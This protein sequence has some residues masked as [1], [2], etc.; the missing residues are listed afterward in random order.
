MLSAEGPIKNI[1]GGG[2][3]G[4]GGVHDPLYIGK[5]SGSKTS[6]ENVF[7]ILGSRNAYFG[8]PSE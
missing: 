8:A 4:H 7:M 1:G 6:S 5:G 3:V 2:R